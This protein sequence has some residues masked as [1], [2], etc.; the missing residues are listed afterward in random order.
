MAESKNILA[1]NGGSSSLKVGLFA[2]DPVRQLAFAEVHRIGSNDAVLFCALGDQK[3]QRQSLGKI[4]ASGA[5]DQV[6][7]LL[8][9]FL[10]DGSLVGIGHRV[11]HGGPNYSTPQTITPQ[12]MIELR[13]LEPFDPEHLPAQLRLIDALR[14]RF[15]NVLHVACF[16]TAFHH[17][18]P[19]V[20]KRLP[21]PRSLDEV[22]VRRYGFHGISFSY[23]MSELRRIDV[24]AATGRVILAHLGNGASLAAVHNGKCMDTSMS[25]TPASGIPMGTRSGD[26]DPGLNEYLARTTSLTAEQ[27]NRMVHLESGLLG[28]SETTADMEQLLISQSSDQRAAEAV[29]IF[30]YQVRK[31][32]GAYAAALGGVDTLVFAGGIGEHSPEIRRRICSDLGFLGIELEDAVNGQNAAKISMGFRSVDVLVIPTREEQMIAQEVVKMSDNPNP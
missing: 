19:P 1:I 4:E 20:S 25:L 11:V 3:V 12:V 6:L 29:D 9:E 13:K 23:L 10:K 22:G 31:C 24:K 5:I 21:I 26:L 7:D 8:T 15:A 30:C 32:I 16:D 17:D 14:N 2:R 27:F 28:I 18:L